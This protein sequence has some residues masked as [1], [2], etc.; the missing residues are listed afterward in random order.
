MP[1][2]PEVETVRRA[3]QE[4]VVGKTIQNVEVFYPR[5]LRN[6]STEHIF[7]LLVSGQLIRKIG[8]KGKYLIFYM[9]SVTLISHLRMEGKYIY[10]E[11]PYTQYDKHVHVIFHFTDGTKL[12]YHDVRKFGT[13]DVVAR[14]N[15]NQIKGFNSLGQEPIAADFSIELFTEQVQSRKEA[16]KQILLN[17]EIICGLG[18]I[19]VDESLAISKLHPIRTG[20][21]L[22]ESEIK[23]L[24]ENIQELLLKAIEL[25]GSSVKSFESAHGKGSM[26]EHLIVYG[27]KDQPCSFCG[28]AIEKIKVG[29]RGTHFCPNCQQL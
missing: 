24:V 25:G 28:T 14:G 18:N 12:L 3:L 19:Y 22:S 17:Q 5:I 9:D 26:Q 27:K 7:R 8:R 16:I 10:S 23:L 13:M 6:L 29:G 21:S 20:D 11:K 1:E 2:L 15:E 4:T